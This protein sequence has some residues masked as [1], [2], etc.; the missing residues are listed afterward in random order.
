MRWVSQV[1]A[2]N[3]NRSISRGCPC[4]SALISPGPTPGVSGVI[5]HSPR[6]PGE[7]LE[8]YLMPIHGVAAGVVENGE[9]PAAADLAATPEEA[10]GDPELVAGHD[11]PRP[12]DRG[13]A[14]HH[15]P[16]HLVVAGQPVLTELV[17]G[18]EPAERQAQRGEEEGGGDQ[19]GIAAGA[20]R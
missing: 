3:M 7:T 12:L 20:G 15:P 16:D 17:R 5:R 1:A 6:D 11:G 18:Q 13:V 19:V 10:L 9:R 2:L 8:D 14:G 4:R